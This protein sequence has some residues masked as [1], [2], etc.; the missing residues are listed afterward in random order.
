MAR[1]IDADKLNKDLTDMARYQPIHKQ[2]TILGVV[3]T[4]KNFP[5]TDVVPRVY[6]ERLE[7]DVTRL[8]QEKDDLI[9]NYAECMKD[10]AREIFEE[11]ERNISVM[12][13]P[14]QKIPCLPYGFIDLL[15]KKHTEGNNGN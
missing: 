13:T 11:I 12:E 3:S 10:Y 1:Y 15:K 7:Q 2:S 14:Y 5:T 8:A 6:V 4:I 9:K